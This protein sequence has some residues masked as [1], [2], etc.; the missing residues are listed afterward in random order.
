MKNFNWG[1]MDRTP[2][3]ALEKS[4]AALPIAE[5]VQRF[6]RQTI[7]DLEEGDAWVELVRDI[8]ARLPEL[9]NEDGRAEDVAAEIARTHRKNLEETKGL[10]DEK[11][12]IAY[13]IS[14]S[15][16]I[17]QRRNQSN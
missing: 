14:L 13:I 17:R 4:E 16:A 1:S 12:Q 15:R 6:E 8:T 3:G 9:E 5:L 2:A 11:S 10:S 7:R